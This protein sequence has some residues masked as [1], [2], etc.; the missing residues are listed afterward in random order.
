[1]VRIDFADRTLDFCPRMTWILY[2]ILFVIGF[3]LMLPKYL[4]RMAKRGGYARD[5]SQR[6][7]R[8]RPEVESRL[9]E[10]RR[11]WVHAVSV[12]E[13]FVALKLMADWRARRPEIRFVLTTNT[14]TGHAVAGRQLDPRDVL[15]YFPLDVP[16]IMRKALDTIDPLALVLVELELWPNLIRLAR[17]RVIPIVL[18]NGRVSDHSYRGYRKLR[19]FTRRVLPMLD[20][21]CVQAKLDAE[22]LVKLGAN[23]DRVRVLGTAKY[24]V[25]TYDPSGESEARDLLRRSQVSDADLVM[26]GGSTWAGEEH[27]LLD[28]YKGLKTRYRNLLLVLAPR[29]VE[30]SPAVLQAIK[31]SHMTVVRRSELKDPEFKV[32]ARPQVFLLDTT[33]ELKNFYACADVIFV[34]KS[35][36]QHGGQNPIEPAL[37]GK[38]VV[39]GPNMENFRAVV[40]DMREAG[41][42]AEVTDLQSLRRTLDDL[43]ANPERRRILGEAAAQVV[44]TKVGTTART[45]DLLDRLLE[46]DLSP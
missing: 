1:M 46:E 5:F 39:V 22:R 8:Y 40:E 23:P 32:R 37:Y 10:G 20:V 34:G 16:C 4:L 19:F 45:L 28:A 21:L 6:F 27:A 29:H 33:G 43:C 18:V 44:R 11:I 25:A 14:S 9:D 15:L 24:D 17:Q 13:V 30:R 26:V 3:L 31:D 2:N 38:P 42:L 35:L 36:T 7:A 41:A 12:G